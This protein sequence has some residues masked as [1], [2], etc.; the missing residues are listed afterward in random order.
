MASP[1]VSARTQNDEAEERLYGGLTS[2]ARREQRRERLIAAGFRLFGTKGFEDTSIEALCAEAG[3]GIRAFYDE[4]GSRDAVFTAAFFEVAD[5]AFSKLQADLIATDGTPLP[6]R[7]QSA[8]SVYLHYILDDP[9]RARLTAV[10]TPRGD[11]ELAAKRIEFTD[12]FAKLAE[13]AVASGGDRPE[14]NL[15]YW[16]VMVVGGVQGLIAYWMNADP[17]PEIDDLAS[18]A[19]RFLLRSLGA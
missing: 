11:M 19:A 4:F 8:L 6:D 16:S 13:A 17:R 7:L 14:G 1:K 18:E 2:S 9:R 5:A 10:D 12:R 15:A 3:V